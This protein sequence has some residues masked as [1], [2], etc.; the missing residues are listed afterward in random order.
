MGLKLHFVTGLVSETWNILMRKEIFYCL[1]S[2]NIQTII[3]N[4]LLHQH[5]FMKFFITI[6]IF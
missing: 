6:L 3:N 4:K 2:E 5:I 1:V